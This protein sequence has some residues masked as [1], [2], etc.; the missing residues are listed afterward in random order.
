M[1]FLDAL[2]S[3]TVMVLDGAMGTELSRRGHPD[4]P[5]CN[6]S[7]PEAVREVHLDYLRAGSAALTTN[8]LTMNRIYVGAHHVDVDVE[9][10]NRAGASLAVSALEE[11]HARETRYVLGNLSATGQLLEP[12]GGFREEDFVSAYREQAGFLAEGGVDGFIIETIVD[13]REAVCAL[14]GC[15]QAAPKLPA[16]ACLAFYTTGNGGRTAMGNSAEDCARVLSREGADAVGANCG[17]LEPEQMAEIVRTMA[18]AAVLPVA[19]EPNAGIPRLVGGATLYEMT[20]AVFANG[21]L[22]CRA[23]GA[24]ILGGCCGTTPE[25]I[26]ALLRMLASAA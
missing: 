6:L 1:G 12:L 8:T 11:Y 17:S 26:R 20:P 16:I 7:A 14:R 18:G 3:R 4:G 2:R 10:V 13:L 19:V 5:L 22:R 24:R 21:L 23:A 25:H 15:R 9:K